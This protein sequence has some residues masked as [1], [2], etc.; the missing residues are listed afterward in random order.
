MAGQWPEQKT[1]NISQT[2]HD[3]GTDLDY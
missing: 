2:A 3:T 1:Y